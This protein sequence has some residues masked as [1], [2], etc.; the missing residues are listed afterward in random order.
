MRPIIPTIRTTK[1]PKIKKCSI[2]KNSKSKSYACIKISNSK[3]FHNSFT[4]GLYEIRSTYDSDAKKNVQY[5]N[6]SKFQNQQIHY[7]TA[8]KKSKVLFTFSRKT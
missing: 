5:R 8:L 3:R 2:K 7:T 6:G 4:K 1:H